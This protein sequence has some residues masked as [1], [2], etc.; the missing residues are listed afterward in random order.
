LAALAGFAEK[1]DPN[2]PSQRGWDTAIIAKIEM[3]ANRLKILESEEVA[4]FRN[5]GR[6]FAPKLK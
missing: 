1:I 5:Y 3:W 2:S 4:V 6:M